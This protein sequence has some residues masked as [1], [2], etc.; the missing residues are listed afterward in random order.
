MIVKIV[1]KHDKLIIRLVIAVLTAILGW[2]S[3]SHHKTFHTLLSGASPVSQ[4]EKNKAGCEHA[5]G[6]VTWWRTSAGLVNIRGKKSSWVRKLKEQSVSQTI[7]GPLLMSITG[8]QGQPPSLS[9]C[10]ANPYR[11]SLL[12]FIFLVQSKHHDFT[13]QQLI[14]V[15]DSFCPLGADKASSRR[16]STHMA[17]QLF[18]NTSLI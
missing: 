8:Q 5:G 9:G 14:P 3:G 2:S 7:P 16:I 17:K 12:F 11:A 18:Q 4:G 10:W 1:W 15:Y 13:S 6:L